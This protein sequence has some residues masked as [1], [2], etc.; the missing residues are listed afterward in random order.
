[1][2]IGLCTERGVL[3]PPVCADDGKVR[4]EY[5]ACIMTWSAASRMSVEVRVSSSLSKAAREARSSLAPCSV[6]YDSNAS[7]I[8]RG[9]WLVEVSFISRYRC[10]SANEIPIYA[11]NVCFACGAMSAFSSPEKGR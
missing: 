5:I 11:W 3:N 2:R 9:G 6:E 4:A 8:G 10:F 7:E 1:M